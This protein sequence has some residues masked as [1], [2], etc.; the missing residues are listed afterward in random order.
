MTYNSDLERQR[1]RA[2]LLAILALLAV[3][4]YM[5]AYATNLISTSL[6][7][8][9]YDPCT[10]K[11]VPDGWRDA[12]SATKKQRAKEAREYKQYVVGVPPDFLTAGQSM[13]KAECDAGTPAAMAAMKARE[14]AENAPPTMKE[15]DEET[16]RR[17]VRE[18]MN[19]AGY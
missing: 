5:I 4:A 11:M 16:D 1:R 6:G 14:D 10:R 9:S 19:K 8:R 12:W 15:L 13:M 2:K 17:R 7:P 3:S 18:E